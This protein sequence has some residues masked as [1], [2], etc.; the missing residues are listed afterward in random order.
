MELNIACFFAGAGGLDLGFK[1]AGFNAIWANEFDK[2]IQ[3][4]YSINFPNVTLNKNSITDLKG[5]DIPDV[6][7]F[8]GGPPCQ[9]W[10]EGGS[11]RGIEDK[12]G[13]VFLDY[14][15]LVKDKNPEFFLA[16]NVPGILFDKH[17]AA[18][19]N[20]LESFSNS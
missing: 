18:F 4:T 12:R 20:I 2:N 16:E 7:G 5:S 19:E 3:Q 9:S 8:V 1:M 11:S 13:K 17:G 6:F 14:V 15:R 10:S